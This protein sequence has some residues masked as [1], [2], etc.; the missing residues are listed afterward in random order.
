MANDSNATQYSYRGIG[1]FQLL[2]LAFIILKLT[3][4]IAWSWWWVLAPL[5]APTTLLLGGCFI[6]FFVVG[7]AWFAVWLFESVRDYCR[8]NRNNRKANQ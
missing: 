6:G 2:T 8:R 4:F 5:W 1:F 7:V 3:G